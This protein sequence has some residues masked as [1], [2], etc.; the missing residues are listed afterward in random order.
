MK[1]F[2]A[3]L[4]LSL[5]AMFHLACSSNNAAPSSP[6]SSGGANHNYPLFGSFGAPGTGNGQFQGPTGITVLHNTIFV[7]DYNGNRV[8]KFDLNGN[9][10]ASYTGFTSP[11]A[12][13]ADTNGILYITNTGATNMIQPMDQNGNWLT[14]WGTVGTGVGQFTAVT[15]GIAV[16]SSNRVYVADRNNN[17]I[18]R[19]SNT[20]TGC[21]T[22]G[23]TATGT[24][25]GQFDSPYG[26]F[27][28]KNGNL[29]VADSGNDRIQEFNSSLTFMQAFGTTGS[30]NGQFSS[31]SDVRMDQDGNL[32]VADLS[33]SRVQKVSSTGTYIQLIG[34]GWSSPYIS[35]FDANNYLYIPDFSNKTVS[36][37]SPN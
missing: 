31:P 8:E 27:I 33:N 23:G 9:F 20:G 34:T 24:A 32:I 25:N 14:A 12:I 26:V 21:V 2:V 1:R 4:G 15:R 22:I 35:A 13:A 10:L 11:Y 37:F 7:V 29:W 18:Q 19:C 5:V 6:S 17:R 28:D 36:V 3:A 16:D 30:G